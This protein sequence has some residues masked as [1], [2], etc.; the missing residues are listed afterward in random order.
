MDTQLTTVAERAAQIRTQVAGLVAQKQKTEGKL[1]EEHGGIRRAALKRGELI[2]SLTGANVA[3]SRAAH[4]GIDELDSAIRVSERLAES[5]QK[6]LAKTV[7][8]IEV[9]HAELAEAE[10]AIRAEERAKALEAF[11]INL[12]QAARRAGE[13]L[14]SARSDLAALN[15]LVTKALLAANGDTAHELNIHRI[16]EPIFA[17]FVDQQANLDRRGWRLV[18]TERPLQFYIRPMT[19]G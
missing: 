10:R 13:T 15:A 5:L 9:L 2:E 1:A 8:E 6:A 12:K 11:Q 3:D 14:D 4:R 7:Q 16:V 17:D 18:H 19:R